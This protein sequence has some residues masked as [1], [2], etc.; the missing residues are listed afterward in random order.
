MEL[1]KTSESLY[2]SCK[3][4]NSV[5]NNATARPEDHRD[6]KVFSLEGKQQSRQE[7][8][9]NKTSGRTETRGHE[10][11]GIEDTSTASK[12]ENLEEQSEKFFTCENPTAGMAFVDMATPL[13]V[14]NSM[15]IAPIAVSSIDF[16]WVENLILTTVESMIISEVNG[17]QLVELVLD[18][19]VF[20]PEV[21]AGTNLTLV[22]SGSELS[23]KFS[24]FMDAT[25]MKDA[26]ELVMNNPTQ[27]STLMSTLKQRQLTLSEF[28]VGSQVVQ[29]PKLEEIQ[30]PLHMIAA[31]MRHQDE[32][33][34]QQDQRE[35][36][37]EQRDQETTQKIK[38]VRL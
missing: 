37:G 20:V 8:T 28:S 24:N 29:L 1:N 27:L 21:F 34:D 7:R 5:Q 4:D 6:V 36:Q 15:E 12:E 3:T 22:Q 25:Q 31:T 23:I 17:E 35:Q 33:K 18:N 32:E 13:V 16:Q 2:S 38:E 9:S 26:A 30:T 14:E 19:N 10:D 11:K